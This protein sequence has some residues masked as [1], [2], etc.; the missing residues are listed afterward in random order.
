[1]AALLRADNLPPRIMELD[2]GKPGGYGWDELLAI[3][4]TQLGHRVRRIAVPPLLQRVVA[5]ASVT[6]ATVTGGIPFLSQG[7]VNEI[8]HPDWVSRSNLLGEA[9]PWKPLVG[10]DEGFPKTLAWYKAAGWL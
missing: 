2:D 1:M 5:A 10:F 3:A 6:F 9:V 7:K 4:E 8:S